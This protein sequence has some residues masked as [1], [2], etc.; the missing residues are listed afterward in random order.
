MQNKFNVK[1]MYTKDEIIMYC[2]NRMKEILTF[3]NIDKGI[4]DELFTLQSII[5]RYTKK[6]F[7]SFEEKV[8]SAI[9][10]TSK[11]MYSN[12][13]DFSLY[14]DNFENT[15]KSIIKYLVIRFNITADNGFYELENLSSDYFNIVYMDMKF[16]IRRMFPRKKIVFNDK[17]KFF[18]KFSN[19]SY[20]DI[21]V[22]NTNKSITRLVDYYANYSN[23]DEFSSFCFI[24]SL[25]NYEK[26]LNEYN[27]LDFSNFKCLINQLPINLYDQKNIKLLFQNEIEE[28]VIHNL[29]FYHKFIFKLF[30]KT[31]KDDYYFEVNEYNFKRFS[32]FLLIANTYDGVAIYETGKGLK[33]IKNVI[34][35]NLNDIATLEN[36]IY[37]KSKK[38]YFSI[39]LNQTFNKNYYSLY[40]INKKINYINR[41]S[42][43]I[44]NE[45]ADTEGYKYIKGKKYYIFYAADDE[46]RKGNVLRHIISMLKYVEVQPNIFSDDTSINY[47]IYVESTDIEK[48]KLLS[49]LI[50]DLAPAK[51]Y[52]ISVLDIFHMAVKDNYFYEVILPYYKGSIKN[53]FD[54]KNNYFY[55][56]GKACNDIIGAIAKQ[57]FFSYEEVI[58]YINDNYISKFIA[59]KKFLSDYFDELRNERNKIY[60]QLCS[61]DA[62][63]S[64]PMYYEK[65]AKNI[66]KNN[67]RW[68]SEYKLYQIVRSLYPDAIYQYKSQWLQKQSLD[69]F[70][71]SLNVAIEY[72]GLQH[73]KPVEYF[74]DNKAYDDLVERDKI[75]KQL[76]E[77]NGVDLIEW[78]YNIPISEI[79][80]KQKLKVLEENP[81]NNDLEN[82]LKNL[83]KFEIIK[84]KTRENIIKELNDNIERMSI[85]IDE[86]K[87]LM[88]NNKEIVKGVVL[89]CNETSLNMHLFNLEMKKETN[90][91]KYDLTRL[92]DSLKISYYHLDLLKKDLSS[93]KKEIF[94]DQE[95]KQSSML[96]NRNIN[97]NDNNGLKNNSITENIL[98]YIKEIIFKIKKIIQKIKR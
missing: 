55:K 56:L 76:C 13:L 1:K 78:T 43:G 9:K 82:D 81:Y 79:T 66:K 15:Y 26:R 92:K 16:N 25:D 6:Y 24:G 58:E 67:I 89:L 69:I 91:E 20:C 21:C 64:A 47:K 53:H 54:N 93:L 19:I 4:I 10:V 3:K 27:K 30:G 57:K 14:E 74:G 62:Y 34:V 68:K 44:Y 35:D 8:Y 38:D 88:N 73:Y 40:L 71:P 83:E 33:S 32:Y 80:V 17:M 94:N 97:S 52:N 85:L 23:H 51:I 39:N 5:V 31:T 84:I 2:S 75:K 90:Y 61:N 72:Q 63:G 41:L 98:L 77:R 7:N 59:S 60:M 18:H 65:Y 37:L 46:S 70:I 95:E 87:N 96:T 86:M 49:Y 22:E 50:N 36:I 11:V 42:I 48:L 29:N 28:I 12:K 45:K